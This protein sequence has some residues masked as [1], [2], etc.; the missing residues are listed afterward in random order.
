MTSYQLTCF[1][2]SPSRRAISSHQD[3]S[4]TR[5]R[6]SHSSTPT[7]RRP[8]SPLQPIGT[9]SRSPQPTSPQAY[10]FPAENTPSMPPS[11]TTVIHHRISQSGRPR[12]SSPLLH[13]IQPP[14]RRLS[15]H[16]ILLLTPFGGSIPSSAFG[17]PGTGMTRVD[18]SLGI[19]APPRLTSTPTPMTS[20]SSYLMRSTSNALDMPRARHHS[21]M[22]PSAPSPLS[23]APMTTIHSVSENSSV[24][25]ATFVS[26]ERSL[27][28]F[29]ATG[30]TTIP[31]TVAMTRSNSLPVLTLRELEA[32]VEKDGEL[33]IRRGG[34]WAWV[35][36]EGAEEDSEDESSVQSTI[37]AV[38][39]VLIYDLQ[40][41][42]RYSE[43]ERQHHHIRLFHLPHLNE[44]YYPTIPVPLHQQFSRPLRFASAPSAI[45]LDGTRSPTRRL[46]QCFR[47]HCARISLLPFGG[48]AQDVGDAN[49]WRESVTRNH[50]SPGFSTT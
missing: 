14:S 45:C 17:A 6:S 4:P 46:G 47:R 33:G 50:S 30:T 49:C 12:R 25:S 35:S 20:S 22:N 27:D 23:S 31:A 41:G 10:T 8:Y 36:G 48:S 15:P 39:K 16:Q 3:E 28:R 32:Q 19:P 13:E 37:C 34:D 44:Q 40:A 11:P 5:A 29:A 7:R 43:H 24:E 21:L 26:H 2:H 38:L 9:N 18:S 1:G 42:R